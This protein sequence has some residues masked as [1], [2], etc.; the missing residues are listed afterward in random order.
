MEVYTYMIIST[1]TLTLRK[2]S[3]F[4]K[5]NITDRVG[6]FQIRERHPTGLECE[7]QHFFSNVSRHFDVKHFNNEQ[8]WLFSKICLH[9]NSSE[10]KHK[11]TTGRGKKKNIRKKCY[12][13]SP[14]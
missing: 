6:P 2:L 10:D 1:F 7:E 5:N 8:F 12:H 4:E 14:V 9:F 11:I 13:L 3:C